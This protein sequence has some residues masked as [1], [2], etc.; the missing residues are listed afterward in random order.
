L[1]QLRFKR[2]DASFVAGKT[3]V[4]LRLVAKMSVRFLEQRINIKF[5]VKVAKNVSALRGLCWEYMKE[6]S[7]SERHKQFKEGTHVE[8][9]NEDSAHHFPRY[10]G[11]CSL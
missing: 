3:F 5:S 7:V 11:Y 2:V 9:T 6:V 10:Q 4:F 1:H 8:I